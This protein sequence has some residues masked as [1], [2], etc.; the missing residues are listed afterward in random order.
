MK[1]LHVK[2]FSKINLLQTE[3]TVVLMGKLTYAGEAENAFN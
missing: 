1:V 3:K 2:M